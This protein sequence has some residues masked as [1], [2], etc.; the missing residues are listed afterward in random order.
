VKRV[1]DL[2]DDARRKER[3]KRGIHI[4]SV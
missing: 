2:M 4:E 3:R 1:A